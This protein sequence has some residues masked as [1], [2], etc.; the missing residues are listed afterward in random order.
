MVGILSV[1]AKRVHRKALGAREQKQCM[2]G[3]HF[4]PKHVLLFSRLFQPVHFTVVSVRTCKWQQKSC[5]VASRDGGGVVGIASAWRAPTPNT[6]LG[7]GFCIVYMAETWRAL[8][9]SSHGRVEHG[10][11]LL[12]HRDVGVP[13]SQVDCLVSGV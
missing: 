2:E 12:C 8:G 10:G 4:L 9:S 6:S 11:L 1:Y 3:Q 5:S 13:G 7:A